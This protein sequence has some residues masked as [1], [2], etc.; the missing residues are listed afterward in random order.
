LNKHLEGFGSDHQEHCVEFFPEIVCPLL[1]THMTCHRAS[2]ISWALYDIARHP[3]LQ[4]AIK[5]GVAVQQT[6][7]RCALI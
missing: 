5:V 7:R 1:C 6:G 3:D 2:T 4:A